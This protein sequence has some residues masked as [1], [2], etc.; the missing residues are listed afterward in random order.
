MNLDKMFLWI[1][2]I[3]ISF[4]FAGDLQYLQRRIW[5]AQA[6]VIEESKSSK[7]GSPRF[8]KSYPKIPRN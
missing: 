7:W 1:I 5:S 6:K 8:F 2:G 4:A 3:V